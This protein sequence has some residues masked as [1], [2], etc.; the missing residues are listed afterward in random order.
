MNLSNWKII[1]E[2]ISLYLWRT[3]IG[4]L[5][6]IILLLETNFIIVLDLPDTSAV[7]S[8]ELG[9]DH[10]LPIC[11]LFLLMPMNMG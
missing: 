8:R 1:Y 3:V 2:I 7:M 11:P 5:I 4:K 6:S 10:V 9:W